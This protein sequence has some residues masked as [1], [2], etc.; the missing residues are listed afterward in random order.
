MSPALCS[1]IYIYIYISLHEIVFLHQRKTYYCRKKKMSNN[2]T[3]SIP[4]TLN[5]LLVKLKILSMIERGK[6]INMGSMTFVD[7]NSWTGAFCRSLNGEGRKGLMVHLSQIVQQAITAIGEYQDTEFCKLVVN[8]LAEAR[9][10][11]QN[12]AT[13]YQHD[14]SIVAQIKVCVS[15]ID[16]QLEKNRSLLDGHQETFTKSV[17]IPITIKEQ[18]PFGPNGIPKSTSVPSLSP[19]TQ[20]IVVPDT[21]SV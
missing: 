6:K 5:D 13:T 2:V 4:A 19:G 12:L 14:P 20:P 21:K 15:N 16:L 17:P 8:H 18:P 11:I 9:I 3:N 7:S 1:Y 10:G